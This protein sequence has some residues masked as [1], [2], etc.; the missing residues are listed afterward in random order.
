MDDFAVFVNDYLTPDQLSI[1]EY[2][3]AS[4]QMFSRTSRLQS[5]QKLSPNLEQIPDRLDHQK[6]DGTLN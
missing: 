2:S 6:L 4:D 5:S 3:C 1:Q